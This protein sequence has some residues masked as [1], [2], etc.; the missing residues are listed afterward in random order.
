MT[1]YDLQDTLYPRTTESIIQYVLFQW[2]LIGD[3]ISKF[4]HSC[5][6][7]SFLTAA[8]HVNDDRVYGVWILGN[9]KA[10]CVITVRGVH[11]S[12]SSANT[13][14]NAIAPRTT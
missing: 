13:V 10:W 9:I 12:S 1:D 7:D 11:N 2:R 3:E 8:D 5:N 14:G 4:N 6:P